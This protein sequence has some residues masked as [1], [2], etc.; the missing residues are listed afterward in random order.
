L[1]AWGGWT[2]DAQVSQRHA[3]T[4]AAVDVENVQRTLL[5]RQAISEVLYEYCRQCD[6]FDPDGI[7]RCFTIDCVADYGPGVGPPAHGRE[8]R[9][10]AAERDLALFAATSHH[11]SNI[12]IEFD[13]PDQARTSSVLY[14]W[15]RP[16]AGGL[17]WQL[18]ARYDDVVVRTEEGWL[19][20][21]RTMRVA[22]ADGFPSG[23]QWLPLGRAPIPST[24]APSR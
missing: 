4:A 11:L 22:G 23:W 9:R 13:G 10:D 6:L 14:A 2:D 12:V 24:G 21:E 18:W 19:I 15:H 16:V 7:A 17:D 8:V 3:V 20:K 5:D 1:A